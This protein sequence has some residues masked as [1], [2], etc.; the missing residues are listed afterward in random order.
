MASKA[1]LDEALSV[2]AKY[3]NGISI[4]HCVSQYPTEYHNVN[5]NTIKY[6]IDTY[7]QYVI[8]YSDHTIGVATPVAAV[9]MGAKIIEKH[10]TV[11]RK[12][13]GIEPGRF[14]RH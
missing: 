3:H 4:L 7:P 5:L 14:A 2:I 11:D 12:D 13:E 8:G 9:A 6:L 10:I 1:E